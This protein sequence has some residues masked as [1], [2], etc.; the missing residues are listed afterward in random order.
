MR[1]FLLTPL[2]GLIVYINVGQTSN[3][4]VPKPTYLDIHRQV[5]DDFRPISETAHV[6]IH[7]AP[8]CG[9]T[10]NKASRRVAYY[11]SW[12]VFIQ[13]LFQYLS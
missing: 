4:G 5:L 13:L 2:T 8:S 11:Q 6:H 12:L 1:A 10:S 3:V 9:A 7:D